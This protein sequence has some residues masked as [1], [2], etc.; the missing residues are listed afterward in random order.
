MADEWAVNTPN[1]KQVRLSDFTLDELVQLESDCDEE[2]WALLSHPFK[3][4]KNAK[5]I[6]AAACA[7]QGVEPAVLTVR[8]LTDVFVQVPDD[9]PEIYEGPIPKGEDDP[10]TAGSS[11]VPSDSS[12]PQNKPEA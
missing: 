10:Q 1:N 11:G 3:S 7:H 9:M 12:G 6:Y 4:A 8:M 2:W 5:Y